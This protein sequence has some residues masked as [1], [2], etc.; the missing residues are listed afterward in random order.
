MFRTL[1]M[2]SAI[3][4]AAPAFADTFTAQP[5]VDAVTIY[6]GLA[7][8]TRQVTLAV[9]AGRHDIIVPDLPAGLSAQGMRLA[10]PE[11]AQLGAVNLAYDRLPVTPDLSAP[12]IVAARDEIERLEGVLRDSAARIAEIRLRAEAAE[13]QIAFLQ[14]L[15]EG[16]AATLPPVADL[17][18]LSQ[19]LGAEVLAAKQTA[20]AAEQ[21]AQAAD[22]ARRDDLEALA[23][24]KQ[25][26]AALT[27]PDTSGAV[28]TF[29][30]AAETAGEVT[31]DITTLEGFADWRPT[32]EMRLTTGDAPV[33]DID[34][35]V[36]ISQSSGQDWTNVHLTL[37]TA[38]PGEQ[39]GPS[40]VWA[41]LRRIVPEDEIARP[42]PMPLAEGLMPQARVLAD[43]AMELAAAPLVAEA[44]FS[45]ATVT[46]VYPTRV[47]IRD[48]VEDLQLPL[49][50][51]RFAAEVWAEAVPSRDSI[52]YRMAEFTNTTDELLLP[53]QALIYAD[54]T[55]LGFGHL[56]ILA[57]GADTEMGFGPLD[58][59]RLTRTMPNRMEGDRGV[60]TTTNQLT[61]TAVITVENLTGQDWDLLVRDVAPYSE[62]QDLK[63]DVT[64]RPAATRRDP[65]GQRGVLEWD[66]RLPAGQEEVITL[67]Y[68]LSWPEGYV[69]R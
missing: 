24:A 42:A 61:E 64:A 52:A 55:M 45:G 26:L 2:T 5:R 11:G 34:R 43:T 6:P 56:P 36:V 15:A 35:A 39:T 60:F 54:G 66:L 32:Y 18:A 1:T 63:V 69:L 40:D 12:R 33:L 7:A 17:M 30:L 37:S 27:A 4:L 31:I 58:G 3:A 49:D 10:A 38:R 44:D 21:E 22:R 20:F 48:G 9:P 62:Q 53:G 14:S 41:P 13:A 65:E 67:D 51:L 50:R 23:E 29:T 28:L 16:Q 46:Y 59:L 8:V 25:A 68:T 57:A 47:D 19:M